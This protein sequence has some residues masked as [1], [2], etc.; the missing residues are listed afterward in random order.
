MSD[1]DVDLDC[2]P[3]DVSVAMI[4]LASCAGGSDQRC[5]AAERRGRRAGRPSSS[6]REGLPCGRSARRERVGR[7]LDSV[8]DR[9]EP[10]PERA[11][12]GFFSE[13]EELDR[14]ALFFGAALAPFLEPSV[15][16]E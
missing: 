8:A 7:S 12:T 2:L 9:L 14:L 6:P 5:A 15:D 4:G 10:L 13:P 1:S 3:C 11:R 16:R